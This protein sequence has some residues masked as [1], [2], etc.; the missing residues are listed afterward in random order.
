MD[1]VNRRLYFM[2]TVSSQEDCC[3]AHICWHHQ[4]FLPLLPLASPG[5]CQ[6]L[7]LMGL[8][9]DGLKGQLSP[10]GPKQL[11]AAC[12]ARVLRSRSSPLGWALNLV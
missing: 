3:S 10:L 4:I 12:L 11:S 1:H 9:P 8:M 5:T 6:V 2:A 7:K